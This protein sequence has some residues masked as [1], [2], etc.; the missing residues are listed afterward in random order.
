MI[1]SGSAFFAGVSVKA[2]GVLFSVS[3]Q[4][5]HNVHVFQY[6]YFDSS[7]KVK[8]LFLR[9]FLSHVVVFLFVISNCGEYFETI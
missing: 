7:V 4:D 9:C 3:F 6:W 8:Y 2:C 5:S 1:N